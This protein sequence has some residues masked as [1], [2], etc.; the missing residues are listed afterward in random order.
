MTVSR[1]R[2]PKEMGTRSASMST[3][4]L[5]DVI[6]KR[7]VAVVIPCKN[8]GVT[9]ASTV[10]AFQKSL[11]GA[12]IIVFDNESD[13][14]S[15]HMARAAGARVVQTIYP[16]RGDL[17]NRIFCDI[18]ADLYVLADGDGTC[19]P[20]DAP[21]L[22]SRL[23]E[24]QSDMVVGTRQDGPKGANNVTSI[25]L[26][27]LLFNS[28]IKDPLSRYRV[29]TKRFV[30]S[31]A[32]HNGSTA[33]EVQLSAHASQLQIP[34]TDAVL[35]SEEPKDLWRSPVPGSPAFR[36]HRETTCLLPS[37]KLFASLRPVRFYSSV[38]SPPLLLGLA[39]ASF[40]PNADAWQPDST[41]PVALAILSL[42]LVAAAF[43]SCVWGLM[44][45]KR[46]RERAEQNRIAF[47]S[48][49][50]FST[51]GGI[52]TRA[53]DEQNALDEMISDVPIC[54][55]NHAGLSERTAKARAFKQVA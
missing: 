24:T 48:I 39:I 10:L 15:A 23:I 21:G 7:S 9:I 38:A 54:A 22:I 17:I 33:V 46:E 2:T 40:L 31:F 36:S 45:D 30:K 35:N 4:T 6:D 13:D 19:D 8:E 49:R 44:L 16:C 37:I 43:V 25:R 50:P 27:Q 18:D 3:Y 51:P 29:L 12:E 1:S 32:A 41:A 5:A 47:H 52:L 14:N 28:R 53:S 42:L 26:F 20:A 34:V 55:S 11:P